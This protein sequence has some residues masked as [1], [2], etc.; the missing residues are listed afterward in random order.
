VYRLVLRSALP[1]AVAL[2]V[3]VTPTYA[4]APVTP[5]TLHIRIQD[6]CQ[7]TS[8]NLALGAPVCSGNG[9]VSFT[10]FINELLQLRF[11]P[12]WQFAPS[13]LQMT[14]GQ[15]FAATN[16]GG[17]THS[18]TEVQAFGGGIVPKLNALAGKTT[19]AQECSLGGVGPNGNLIPAK[20]ALASF[21]PPG[22]TFT[23]T[24]TDQDV[25]HPV[26][27]QCCIHPWMNAVIKV[28]NR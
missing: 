28:T 19:V 23:D 16:F 3:L 27:Y 17:E 15:S 8:F 9:A 20:E 18:F 25:S 24:E 1:L 21:V 5:P 6:Q 12:Q 14:V 2:T 10:Q 13:Q 4:M 11:A 22:G 26:L 7:A